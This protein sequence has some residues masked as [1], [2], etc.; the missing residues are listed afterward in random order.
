MSRFVELFG[1]APHACWWAPGRVN[2]IG[3]HTDYNDG[4][5]L[6]IAISMGVTAQVAR[7]GDGLLRVASSAEPGPPVES[8]VADLR[9]GSVPGWAAYIAGVVWAFGQAGHDVAGV[10]VHVDGDVPRGAGLS[11]SAALECSVAAAIDDAFGLGLTRQELI[12]LAQHAENRYVG[13]P[14]GIL[15]QAAAMLCEA[16]HALFLDTRSQQSRAIP[17][18]LPAA[19]LE[20][21]VIDTRAPHDLVVSEYAARRADC[22]QAAALLG[23]AALRDISVQALPAALA[24]LESERL[25][26][27]VEHVVT[28]NARVLD[29]VDLLGGGADPR[30]LGELLTASHV[31]LRDRFQ[32]SSRELDLAV[33]SAFSAGA[34]GARMTGGGFG[35]SAIALVDP[36]DVAGVRHAVAAAFAGAGLVD[37][38]VF[39]VTAAAG[40]HSRQPH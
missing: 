21:L 5:V 9:P 37:P 22:E 20:L 31:S 8:A 25:R 36:A 35:G 38:R 32:V 40:A 27:R 39:P 6:P 1:S 3:E 18:D 12:L 24:G 29:A 28:E 16:Q 15:D 14:T 4:F 7:R 13:V 19:G 17:F 30:E 10:D 23:V 26:M 33:D 34:H 2:V 11:S